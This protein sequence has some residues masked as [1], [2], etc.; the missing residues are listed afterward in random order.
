LFGADTPDEVDTL[1]QAITELEKTMASYEGNEDEYP[2][3]VASLERLY[4]LKEKHANKSFRERISPDTVIIVAGN[5]AGILIVVA[6]EHSHVIA[7]N[8]IN[9]AGKLR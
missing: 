6:Y 2:K 7:R 1:T 3:M 9:F 8:A 5:L 4:K